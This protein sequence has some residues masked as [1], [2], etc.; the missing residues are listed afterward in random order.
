MQRPGRVPSGAKERKKLA[1]STST[2]GK[3]WVVYLPCRI[4][5]GEGH[6]QSL[7]GCHVVARMGSYDA[8]C[9]R[10]LSL[11]DDARARGWACADVL[12]EVD[13]AEGLFESAH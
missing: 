4:V 12:V 7:D 11:D 2:K 10:A 1:M 8:A 3:F 6:T 5:A 13:G 9:R